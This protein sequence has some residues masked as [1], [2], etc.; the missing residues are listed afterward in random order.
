MKIEI[1]DTEVDVP[2]Q[3]SEVPL[4]KYRDFLVIYGKEIEAYPDIEGLCWFQ[5]FTGF[6]FLDADEEI[7]K[8]TIDQW[9]LLSP[10]LKDESQ[11]P[12]FCT[13]PV[14][15][16]G[17]YWK[18]Q[19]FT[20]EELD[21]EHHWHNVKNVQYATKLMDAFKEKPWLYLPHFCA[22]FFRRPNESLEEYVVNPASERFQLI[23]QLPLTIAISIKNHLISQD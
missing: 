21:P 12:E 8:Q 11:V 17:E 16:N 9:K 20:D 6:D 1:N 5:Y 3:L 23:L 4:G 10:L 14:E 19:T 15:W 2:F 7:K 22:V 18:F 13:D